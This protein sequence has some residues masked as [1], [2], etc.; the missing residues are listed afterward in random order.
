MTRTPP[1]YLLLVLLYCEAHPGCRRVDI[2]RDVFRVSRGEN[3][4]GRSAY[5]KLRSMAAKGWPIPE[6]VR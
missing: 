5:Q 1:A 6:A 4:A 3:S 2:V